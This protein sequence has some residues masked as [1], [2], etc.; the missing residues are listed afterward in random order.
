VSLTVDARGIITQARIA[1]GGLGY[2]PRRIHEAEAVL[3]GD[4]PGSA[5]F[6]RAAAISNSLSVEGD[7]LYAGDYRRELTRVLTVRA[8]EQASARAREF[9]DA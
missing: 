4:R 2:A 1:V 9:D 3:V 6:E 5:C 7:A 8:L